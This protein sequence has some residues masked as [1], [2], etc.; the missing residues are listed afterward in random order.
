MES[1]VYIKGERTRAVAPLRISRKWGKH[2]RA[3]LPTGQQRET[4]KPSLGGSCQEPSDR[5]R[6]APARKDLTTWQERWQEG[7][8]MAPRWQD[9][10]EGE[11]EK[12][13]DPHLNQRGNWGGQRRTKYRHGSGWIW[14]RNQEGRETSI[15]RF[16]TAFCTLSLRS[17]YH[18]PGAILVSWFVISFTIYINSWDYYPHFTD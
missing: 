15:N 5:P 14:P 13:P 4:A 3:L 2:L 12:A 18:V 7:L 16:M 11:K 10:S 6:Q 8:R 1:C 17:I 9:Q